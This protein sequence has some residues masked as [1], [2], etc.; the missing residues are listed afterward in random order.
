M[1]GG[2]ERKRKRKGKEER[3]GIREGGIILDQRSALVG[4]PQVVNVMD[5]FGMG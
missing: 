2:G 4:T 1:W 3:G 5:T